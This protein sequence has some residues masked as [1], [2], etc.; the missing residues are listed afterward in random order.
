M[1]LVQ[2]QW[3]PNFVQ[4]K[5]KL[6]DLRTIPPNFP[7]LFKQAKNHLDSLNIDL[8]NAQNE[9]EQQKIL[10]R[11]RRKLHKILRGIAIQDAI[12]E[13]E[14]WWISKSSNFSHFFSHFDVEPYLAVSGASMF[15]SSDSED[16]K[17]SCALYQ[18]LFACRFFKGK[19]WVFEDK[20][21]EVYLAMYLSLLCKKIWSLQYSEELLAIANWSPIHQLND[22]FSEKIQYT[23]YPYRWTEW[24]EY[25][26]NSRSETLGVRK[27]W[28]ELWELWSARILQLEVNK[29]IRGIQ[30]LST[31]SRQA[32]PGVSYANHEYLAIHART[33]RSVAELMSHLASVQASLWNIETRLDLSKKSA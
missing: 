20:K 1:A 15:S 22:D 10:R 29:A 11:Q 5:Q 31:R 7:E 33:Q 16:Q 19:D 2:P 26:Y 30:K 24:E 18:D 28:R 23:R 14:R 27:W 12:T 9:N 4:V 3:S 13:L 32:F 8:D 21:E 25:A 17:Q 6:S